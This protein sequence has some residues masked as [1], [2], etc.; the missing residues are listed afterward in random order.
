MLLF[1]L[2][3][4]P[5]EIIK[6]YATSYKIHSYAKKREKNILHGFQEILSPFARYLE[7]SPMLS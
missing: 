7:S 1:I 2:V 3:S 5:T 4:Y 6:T